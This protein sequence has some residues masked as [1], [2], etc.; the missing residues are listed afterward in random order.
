MV[1]RR[2]TFFLPEDLVY[3]VR[4]EDQVAVIIPEDFRAEVLAIFH[5]LYLLWNTCS[6]AL[7]CSNHGDVLVKKPFCG[8]HARIKS[9][10]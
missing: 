6:V 2:S 8:W 9:I 3:Y 7:H 10:H 5:F 1:A 4:R